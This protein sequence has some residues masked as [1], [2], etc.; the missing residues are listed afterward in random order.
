MTKNRSHLE[1]P[2]GKIKDGS[3]IDT[4]DYEYTSDGMYRT[5]LEL[6]RYD[7]ETENCIRFAYWRKVKHKRTGNEYWHWSSQTTWIFSIHDTEKA[8]KSC[9]RERMVEDLRLNR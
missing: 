5:R 2:D 1:Y 8:L 3:I 9:S 7:K 6:I 4:T